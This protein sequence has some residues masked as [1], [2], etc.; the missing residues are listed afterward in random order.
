MDLLLA[1]VAE[2]RS[3]LL[4]V[5]HSA[6]LAGLADSVRRLQQGQLHPA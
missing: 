5:T 1:L 2:E 6:E 4:Y 3:A